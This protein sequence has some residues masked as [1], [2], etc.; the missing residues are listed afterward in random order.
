MSDPRENPENLE[1]M[2]SQEV[3]AIVEFVGRKAI[4]D[5]Q[6]WLDQKDNQ[7]HWVSIYFNLTQRFYACSF[8]WIAIH[9][10]TRSSIWAWHYNWL[11]V[12][13]CTDAVLDTNM[14][15]GRW[16]AE[17]VWKNEYIDV[18]AAPNWSVGPSGDR[19][20]P[21]MPGRPGLP[22]LKGDLGNPGPVGDRGPFGECNNVLTCLVNQFL[23]IRYVYTFLFGLSISQLGSYET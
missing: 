3:R 19:G 6:V 2:E 22:G 12:Y 11:F 18:V 21:G 9:Q 5:L 13:N 17:F 15:I 16:W 1:V 14:L 23:W 20:E 8:F 7:D 10:S 4:L